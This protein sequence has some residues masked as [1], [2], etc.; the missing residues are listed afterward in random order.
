MLQSRDDSSAA[1][2]HVK[3]SVTSGSPFDKKQYKKLEMR[4]SLCAE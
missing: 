2:K 1:N 4:L 3:I